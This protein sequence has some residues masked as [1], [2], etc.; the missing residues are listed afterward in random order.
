MNL[1][2]PRSSSSGREVEPSPL[3][4]RPVLEFGDWSE[5]LSGVNI[6]GA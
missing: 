6:Q 2:L 5:A 4:A 3:A 1:F